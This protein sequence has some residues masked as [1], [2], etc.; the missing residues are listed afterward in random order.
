ML[1]IT[2]QL[3]AVKSQIK[4][5]S[6]THNV[7]SLVDNIGQFDLD[8]CIFF[9]YMLLQKRAGR[10]HVCVQSDSWVLSK[11]I[12]KEINLEMR[13]IAR[14]FIHQFFHRL[15]NLEML[16]LQFIFCLLERLT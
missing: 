10:V 13:F 15:N 3:T 5:H 16:C 9:A 6:G 11:A 12:W 1:T 2:T 14:P 8:S 7:V 4:I